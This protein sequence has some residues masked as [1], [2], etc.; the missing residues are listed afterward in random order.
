MSKDIREVIKSS[1]CTFYNTGI[2]HPN[3][4]L[5]S[6]V[7]NIVQAK[8][9]WRAH[10]IRDTLDKPTWRVY[11]TDTGLSQTEIAQLKRKEGPVATFKGIMDGLTKGK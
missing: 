9:G 5:L 7:I 3:L 6:R 2:T 10:A 1:C 11:I 4:N 8:H